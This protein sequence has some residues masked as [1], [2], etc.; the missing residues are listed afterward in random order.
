MRL[1]LSYGFSFFPLISTL[2]M[3]E[4]DFVI[5]YLF[6]VDLFW[7]HNSGCVFDRLALVGSSLFFFN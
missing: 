3:E 6:F 5:F 4:L 2:D 1:F 7:F